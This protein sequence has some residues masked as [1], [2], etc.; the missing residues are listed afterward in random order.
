MRLTLGGKGGGG[1]SGRVI[2]WLKAQPRLVPS[3]RNMELSPCYLFILLFEVQMGLTGWQWY[4]NE[5]Y[6]IQ[7]YTYHTKQSYKNTHITQ[8]TPHSATQT[9]KNTLHIKNTMQ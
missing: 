9:I 7:K 4:Y 6:V 3:L 8:N 5:T 1:Q 2:M